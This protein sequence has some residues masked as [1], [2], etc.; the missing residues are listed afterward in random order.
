MTTSID[1]QQ[2]D[3]YIPVYDVMPEKWEEASPVLVERLKMVTNAI[4]LREIGWFLDQEVISGKQYLPGINESTNGGSNQQFRTI[5]RKVIEFP[6]INIG[7][8]TQPHGLTIDANF[9]LIQMTAAGTNTVAFTGA[10]IPNTT[11]NLSYDATNVILTSTKAY[12]R[13]TST[14]EY[15]YEL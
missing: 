1:S 11:D 15:M 8:N 5:F 4:N 2:F 12:T 7:V 14:M 3:S 6:I 13:G 10:P 9:T